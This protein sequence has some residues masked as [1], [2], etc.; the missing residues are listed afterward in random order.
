MTELELLHRADD[1]EIVVRMAYLIEG[2]VQRGSILNIDPRYM[3]EL[4]KL[5][6]AVAY[7]QMRDQLDK[8]D[9]A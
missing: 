2:I 9:A 4:A 3:A 6:R 8:E 5:G 1:Q 7:R